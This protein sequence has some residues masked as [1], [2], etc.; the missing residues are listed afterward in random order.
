M[1]QALVRAGVIEDS[2]YVWWAIR[3][4]LG[5]PT[6]ELRAPDC[7][8]L[9]DDSIAIAALYRSLARRL[10]RNP[11][12]NA[13]S[14][15]VTRAHRGGEQ[16]ARAALR[17]AR[18][19]RHH[20][21]TAR[22]ASREMLDQVIEDVSADA[23]ALGCVAEI[24]RCR[25]IVGAGTSADAQLAV[26]EA[27]RQQRRAASSALGAVTDWIASRDLAVS[28][29]P[30]RPRPAARSAPRGRVRGHRRRRA[31]A[32]RTASASAPQRA[33]LRRRRRRPAPAGRSSLRSARR[34]RRARRAPRPAPADGRRRAR[35][36]CSDSNS[37]PARGDSA[38]ARHRPRHRPAR[39]SAR[40]PA[41]GRRSARAANVVMAAASADSGPGRGVVAA[42][43]RRRDLRS[44]TAATSAATRSVLA[45][46]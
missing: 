39:Q 37:P 6:L 4:S 10:V 8:T 11:W 24:R 25:A 9:V 44:D 43:A 45:G 28:F 46:K 33:A 29:T 23:E 42:C 20:D 7:C 16:M 35:R 30:R 27:Q 17:R 38:A 32:A 36:G 19:F 22:S 2:S 12:L 21:G 14:T 40:R 31:R 5:H 18:H 15:P 3:P 41:A 13:D 1:S 34:P 26:F